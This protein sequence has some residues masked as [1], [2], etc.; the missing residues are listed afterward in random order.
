MNGNQTVAPS[1]GT[2]PNTEITPLTFDMP[3]QACDCH[4]HIHAEGVPFSDRRN[5]TPAS[6]TPAQLSA[7]H[8]RLGIQRLVIVQPSVYGGDHTATLMG[9][10]ER[11]V[12]ARGI[13]VADQETS[14]ETLDRLDRAGV[15]GLRINL[16]AAHLDDPAKVIAVIRQAQ[17]IAEPR[18]WHL[19]INA[20]LSI[21]SY[22]KE[23]FMQSPVAIV[24]DHFGRANASLGVDQAGFQDLLQLVGSGRLYVKLSV[25]GGPRTDYS[26]FAPLARAVIAAN[27]ER[28]L[29]GSNW[30]HPNVKDGRARPLDV[31]ALHDVDDGR[32]LNELAAWAPDPETRQ[33]ILAD[34]PARLYRF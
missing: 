23:I 21:L 15:T 28:C 2:G 25:S 32:V 26:G 17:G 1:A 12:D 9:L 18:G 16:A 3:V 29:W 19:E 20:G 7:L 34:N 10:R 33:K 14:K 8:R 5:Y 11:G 27:D 31:C 4:T 24:V 13:A 30:P 22:L 6:A